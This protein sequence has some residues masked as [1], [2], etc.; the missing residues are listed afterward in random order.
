MLHWTVFV[1]EFKKKVNSNFGEDLH[2]DDSHE[3]IVQSFVIK[4]NPIQ[5]F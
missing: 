2:V 5:V 1:F 4:P 3:N